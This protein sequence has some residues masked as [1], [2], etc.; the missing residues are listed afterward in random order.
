MD[1]RQVIHE[2]AVKKGMVDE[3]EMLMSF[4]I[5]SAWSK[6]EEEEGISTYIHQLE[7]GMKLHE[8]VGLLH[9]GLDS[10]FSGSSDKP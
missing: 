3:D 5:V 1:L 4:I 2:D 9:M 7:D 8:A 6:L 10:V